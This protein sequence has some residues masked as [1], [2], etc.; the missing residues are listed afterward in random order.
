MYGGIIPNPA[1]RLV[2]MLGELVTVDGRVQIPGFYDD[3]RDVDDASMK[4]LDS[5]PFDAPE[6]APIVGLS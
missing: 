3:I 6:P 5:F 2:R 1:W 4:L